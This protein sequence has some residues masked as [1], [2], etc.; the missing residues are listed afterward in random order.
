MEN[1]T[2]NRCLICANA[3]DPQSN[4]V[5]SSLVQG[6]GSV[7]SVQVIALLHKLLQV[8]KNS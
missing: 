7:D 8:G 4:F 2:Q 3:A 6:Q 5:T 1:I